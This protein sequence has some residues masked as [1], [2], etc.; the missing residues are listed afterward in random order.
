MN[1]VL[2]AFLLIA[3][4]LMLSGS[5]ARTSVQRC[6]GDLRYILR[7]EK[8]EIIDT[9]KIS[10]RYMRINGGEPVTSDHAIVRQR[11]DESLLGPDNGEERTDSIKI[12]FI[13]SGCGLRLVEVE[14][15]YE[16]LVMALR[17]HNVPAETNFLVDSVPFSKGTY[18]IDFKGEMRLESLKLNRE[19][20]RDNEG[21]YLW[22]GTAKAG[23]LVSAENWIKIRAEK[24][25]V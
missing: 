1:I 10:L 13:K 9:E 24:R 4:T 8:G 18:E 16:N 3:L 22:R 14:L 21:K 2:K 19:G 12:L 20:V 11:I 17:L 23:Y 7:N 25:R 15:E 6:G 5:I